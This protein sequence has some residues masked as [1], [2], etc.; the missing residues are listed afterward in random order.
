MIIKLVAIGSLNRLKKYAI[1]KKT[2]KDKPFNI[3]KS[4]FT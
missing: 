3:I 1:E 4:P 2:A